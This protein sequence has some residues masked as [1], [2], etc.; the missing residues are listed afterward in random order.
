MKA[1]I[2][3]D[4]GFIGKP[5][6]DGRNGFDGTNGIDG[7]D[8]E[9]L[10]P[11]GEWSFN[12]HYN[13]HDMV[14]YKGSSFVALTSGKHSI[15]GLS[16]KFWQLLAARGEQGP[17]GQGHRG[18]AGVDGKDGS[19]GFDSI[20]TTFNQDTTIGQSIY[21]TS[22]GNASLALADNSIT[23]QAIGFAFSDTLANATGQYITEG[24]IALANLTP[25]AL[26]F[27]S[28]DIPGAITTTPPA[29]MGQFVAPVGRAVSSTS[30][31]IEIQTTVLL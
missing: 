15:P 21:L 25:G 30:L 9:G 6:R 31:D 20:E 23:T 2:E 14:S 26:Y 3:D 4:Y 11:A 28:A 24:Q 12:S 19:G 18:R 8:G 16:K 13:R 29:N 5:G 1:V 7:A 17:A 22:S 27:L 10:N